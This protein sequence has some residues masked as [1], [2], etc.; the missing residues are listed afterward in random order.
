MSGDSDVWTH[1]TFLQIIYI[2]ALLHLGYVA[3]S[4]FGPQVFT[5]F[6]RDQCLHLLAY[7]CGMQM[8][9]LAKFAFGENYTFE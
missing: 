1:T 8:P 2:N 9:F 4:Q 7:I 5:H 3:V 6:L